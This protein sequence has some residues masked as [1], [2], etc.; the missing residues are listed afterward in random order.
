MCAC[1]RT[2]QWGR[3]CTGHGGSRDV[4]AGTVCVECD[5]AGWIKSEAVEDPADA[6]ESK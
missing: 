2:P 5:G 6:N 1:G 3:A 4:N